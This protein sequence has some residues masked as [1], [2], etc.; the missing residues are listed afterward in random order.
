MP[1]RYGPR[2]DLRLLEQFVQVCDAGSL[3]RAA[4]KLACTQP[5]LTRRM[6]RLERQL[7]TQL[8]VR[9]SRGVETTQ[10]GARLLEQARPLL[11][12]VRRVQAEIDRMRREPAG[13]VSVC[14][15]TSFHDAVTLPL[16]SEMRRALPLV[17]LRVVEAMDAALR[18]EIAAGV[19]IG[20]AMHDPERAIEGAEP[21][22]L[23]EDALVLYGRPGAFP[24]GARVSLE[25]LR[26]VPLILPS[27]RNHMR[28]KLARLA[29]R[30]GVALDIVME[31]DTAGL[32]TDLTRRGEGFS[33]TPRMALKPAGED[34]LEHWPIAGAGVTWIAHVRD[35]RRRSPAVA[36]VAGRLVDLCRGRLAAPSP[37]QASVPAAPP[38]RATAG[39]PS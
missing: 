35:T 3:T 39:K 6:L 26:G 10:A 22:P 27:G 30:R 20:V 38:R 32:I 37:S 4:E 17:R 21:I 14:L 11:D 34:G 24:A 9:S 15:P 29:G 1:K 16:I 25:Q 8:L 36:A 31:V 33:V 12:H 7:N 2:M 5:A 23:G 19:D 18:E 28:E 13:E